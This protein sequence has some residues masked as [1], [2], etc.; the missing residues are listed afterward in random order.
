MDF[1]GV[2]I[3]TEY[4]WF[5]I[6]QE[7]FKK[8]ANYDLSKREFSL[9]IG[10]DSN[11]LLTYLE[12]EKNIKI[13][14]KSFQKETQQLFIEKSRDLPPLNGVEK[15]IKNI[16]KKGWILSLAT[17]SKIEKPLFHLKRL[18]L[19]KYFDYIVTADLVENIKPEPDL[20]LKAIELANV[21]KKNAIIIE[22]SKNGLI[23]GMRAGID[24]IICPNRLTRFED[25][26]GCVDIVKSLEEIEL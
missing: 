9:A 14:R 22:D 21:E 23:A 1:D 5:G 12:K 24:V 7:W 13:N 26:T 10:A 17:S 25:F 6:F 19:L 2:I 3:D 8:K 20:F 15:F 18:K 11:R 4:V 16:K